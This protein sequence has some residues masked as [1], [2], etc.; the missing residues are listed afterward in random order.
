[1]NE[2]EDDADQFERAMNT[3][4]D[5]SQIGDGFKDTYTTGRV[6]LE[7]TNNDPLM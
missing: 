7:K 4:N 5:F 1:M 6:Q 3:L 2:N